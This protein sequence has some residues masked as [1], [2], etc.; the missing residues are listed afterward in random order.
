[1]FNPPFE[2]DYHQ[3]SLG[4]A[5]APD[6]TSFRRKWILSVILGVP[7]RYLIRRTLAQRH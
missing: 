2:I 6:K 5:K 3:E 1:M 7:R 4:C